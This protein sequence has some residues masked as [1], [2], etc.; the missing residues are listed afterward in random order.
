MIGDRASR[1]AAASHA[2]RA[3]APE[4]APAAPALF[5]PLL[6]KHCV[7][8]DELAAAEDMPEIR[9]AWALCCVSVTATVPHNADTFTCNTTLLN[10]GAHWRSNC[11]L[12]GYHSHMQSLRV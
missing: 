12:W 3:A 5:C 9:R 8:S 6:T 2:A 7:S 4:A 1:R 11:E 10:A